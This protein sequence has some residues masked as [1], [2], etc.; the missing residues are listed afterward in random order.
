MQKVELERLIGIKV[1]QEPS[2]D[3][4]LSGYEI[5]L[6]LKTPSPGEVNLLQT[7]SPCYPKSLKVVF[8]RGK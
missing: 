1:L 5:L 2:G 4:D 3:E 8:L 6:P 7:Y